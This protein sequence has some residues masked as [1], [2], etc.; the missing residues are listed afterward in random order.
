MPIKTSAGLPAI[1]VL[2]RE[3]IFSI[4]SER[5]VSQDIRPLKIA[6]VNLMPTRQKTE[7]QLLRLLSN[8]PLQI[9]VSL[10]RLVTHEYKNTNEEY[11]ERFYIPST[12]LMAQR[13]DGLII[14]GAPVEK[15]DFAEV[16]YWKELCQVMDWAK[17]GVYSTLY[18]C[19]A[20]FAALFHHYGVPK[21]PL[22][23]K[24]FGVFMNYKILYDDP[25][26]R[27]LDDTFPIVQSRHTSISDEDIKKHDDLI[28]MAKGAETGITLIKSADNREVFMTGHLEY[29]TATLADEYWRDKAKGLEIALP[30]NYFPANNPSLPPQSYWRSS[31]HLFYANWLNYYV[32]Q[33]TPY[34]F[35]DKKEKE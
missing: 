15:L 32:Y 27:G 11:L 25:L 20:A 7:V 14:T 23:E 17:E 28:V 34:N 10:V 31:A 6:I 1:E 29:D 8:T 21:R 5:A 26:L 24:L 16:D 35:I 9:E 33:N 18:L 12:T 2:E 30:K 22:A 3:N 19:W 13:F 4:T